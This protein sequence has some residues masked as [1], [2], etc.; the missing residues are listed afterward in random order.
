MATKIN[1]KEYLKKYLSNDVG[2]SDPN[3]KKKKKKSTKSG[4]TDKLASAS[5][6]TKTK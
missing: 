4:K 5:A 2:T 3:K 6:S 1:Q